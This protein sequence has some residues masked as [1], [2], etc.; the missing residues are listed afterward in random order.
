MIIQL[1]DDM[2]YLI[3]KTLAISHA[4]AHMKKDSVQVRDLK[5]LLECLVKQFISQGKESLVDKVFVKCEP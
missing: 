1:D 2:G 4:V 3:L 5:E